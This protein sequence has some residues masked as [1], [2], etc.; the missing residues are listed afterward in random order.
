MTITNPAVVRGAV[1]DWQCPS[2]SWVNGFSDRVVAYRVRAFGNHNNLIA[3]WYMHV[4]DAR[5]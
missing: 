5:N 1:F 3:N 4:L 2:G